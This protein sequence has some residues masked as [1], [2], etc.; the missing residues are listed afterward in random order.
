M[1]RWEL[2]VGSTWLCFLRALSLSFFS[3]LF[4]YNSSVCA[5]K[6]SFPSLFLLRGHP[7]CNVILYLQ[8]GKYLHTHHMPGHCPTVWTLLPARAFPWAR[9]KHALKEWLSLW[10]HR[11]PH[12]RSTARDEKLNVW[13]EIMCTYHYNTHKLWHVATLPSPN[14]PP[15][16]SLQTAAPATHLLTLLFP[17]PALFIIWPLFSV[18]TTKEKRHENR[19]CFH[20]VLPQFVLL[21]VYSWPTG[22]STNIYWVSER[23]KE[24]A[25]EAVAMRLEKK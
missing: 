12:L 3:V 23:R 4:Y 14:Q 15:S 16:L 18:S 25:S 17:P 2:R 24:N 10:F 6:L 7:L 11:G 5:W 1:P 21:P 8:L 19:N 22:G 20:C 13:S 9:W